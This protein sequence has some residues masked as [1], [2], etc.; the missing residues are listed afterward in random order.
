MSLKHVT[1]KFLEWQEGTLT[2]SNK[3][4][5]E[6][7]LKICRECREYF[8]N[9]QEILERPDI[10]QLPQLSLDPYLPTRI[11]AGEVTSGAGSPVAPR[12]FG[13]RWSFATALAVIGL[14][15]GA[16]LGFVTIDR[17]E[18]TEQEI[19]TAYYEVITQQENDYNLEQLLGLDNGG[20]NE[21]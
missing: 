21:D 14:S 5:V 9:W 8:Q 19:A 10:S 1:K 15:A 4:R 17:N 18:Y 2:G 7:H 3:K 12:T 20:G 11:L 16:I 13:M 6:E